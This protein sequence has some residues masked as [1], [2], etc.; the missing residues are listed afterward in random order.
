MLSRSQY[1]PVSSRCDNFFIEKARAFYV[2]SNSALGEVQDLVLIPK[3]F[4][5]VLDEMSLQNV[6]QGKVP[7]ESEPNAELQR[8]CMGLMND[9]MKSLDKFKGQ[10]DKVGKREAIVLAFKA[11]WSTKSVGELFGRIQAIRQQLVLGV[12]VI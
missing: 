10:L 12:F 6:D 3:D 9:M 7:P 8:Q 11:T 2:A 4:E 1:H 5:A